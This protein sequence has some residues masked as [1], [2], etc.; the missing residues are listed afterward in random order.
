MLLVL[1]HLLQIQ[2]SRC[3]YIYITKCT[4]AKCCCLQQ[5][6]RFFIHSFKQ[7]T[8]IEHT[9]QIQ[10]NFI[11]HNKCIK[12]KYVRTHVPTKDKWHIHKYT[13]TAKDSQCNIIQSL[14]LEHW[15][16]QEILSEQSFTEIW[17]LCSDLHLEHSHPIF[18]LDLDTL[19]EDNVPSNKI[20]VSKELTVL[21]IW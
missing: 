18:S 9:I 8:V 7:N 20:L 14:V 13:C 10:K 6:G 1:V 4:A 19:A 5:T 12:W 3:S 21:K 17:N 16:V 15:P 11:I 2:Q